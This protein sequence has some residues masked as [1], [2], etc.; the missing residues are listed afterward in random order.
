[1]RWLRL[2]V[3]Y[4][5]AVP[6]LA[7]QIT[8]SDVKSPAGMVVSDGKLYVADHATGRIWF[9]TGE[10]SDFQVFV[11]DDR[12]KT[13][14][15]LAADEQ[16]IYVSDPASRSVFRIDK[17]RRTVTQLWKGSENVTPTDVAYL[18]SYAIVDQQ[19]KRSNELVILDE[20]AKVTYRL[21]LDRTPSDLLV[22]RSTGLEWPTS[23]SRTGARLVVADRGTGTVFESIGGREWSSVGKTRFQDEAH[24]PGAFFPQVKEPRSASYWN[25]I[26]YLI[27]ENAIY[28]LVNRGTRLVPLVNRNTPIK[29]P[30]RLLVNEEQLQLLISDADAGKVVSWPLLVPITIELEARRDSSDVLGEIYRYLWKLG[31]LPTTK[32]AL[33]YAYGTNQSCVTV[34][35]L[36]TKARVLLPKTNAAI[37]E[38]LCDANPG[39][40]E[41]GIL[42][43]LPL[44][45]EFLFPLVPFENSLFV[46]EQTLDGD[47]SL[48]AI[49][50]ESI[51]DL[52][53]RSQVTDELLHSLNPGLQSTN[54]LSFK[55]KGAKV[56]IPIQ[57]N[58]YFLA[59]PRVELFSEDSGLLKIA[60]RDPRLS[61]RSTETAE[62]KASVEGE[63]RFATSLSKEYQTVL[64]NMDFHGAHRERYGNGGN[65][66]VLV[67]EDGVDCGHPVFFG[68]GAGSAF[69]SSDCLRPRGSMDGVV[70][71]W[72]ETSERHGTCV[73]SLVGARS[74]PYGEPLAPNIQVRAAKTN[75]NETDLWEA[76]RTFRRSFVLNVSAGSSA[77]NDEQN[78][79]NI[80]GKDSWSRYML[81]VAASGNENDLLKNRREFPARLAREFS[82]VISVGALD[83][84]GKYLWV[85]ADSRQG[86]NFG[87]MVEILAPGESIPCA[88]EVLEDT[89]IY[90]L[91]DGTSMATPLV[92]AVAALL[93]EKGL[94]PGEAKAR[95]LATAE[96][97]EREKNG[98]SVAMFGKLSAERALRDPENLYV[99]ILNPQ[100][101]KTE[102]V[103]GTL[104]VDQGE[105]V[106][107]A[108]GAIRTT[109][110]PSEDI[111]SIRRLDRDASGS[112]LYRLVYFV[113]NRRDR[114][115]VVLEKKVIL[116]GC[117]P[118][119]SRRDGQTYLLMFG[120]G[121]SCST[122][123]V[124]LDH[125]VTAVTDLI[126]PQLGPDRFEPDN[127]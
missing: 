29:S 44:N 88:T 1:M 71:Q 7:Q 91:V 4:V 54:I 56:S 28:A 53:L 108:P 114:G 33:P 83:Q 115:S 51:P 85:D 110:V 80:L 104:E 47:S 21:S 123:R 61:V 117:L 69:N 74:S 75:L 57:R 27:Q 32:L 77:V 82:N 68:T 25:G 102:E 39:Y 63:D 112:Y 99:A 98:D 52:S 3:F 38:I 49:I 6:I 37:E 76:F 62:P 90:S 24:S 19:I 17:E 107:R 40:C 94:T 11:S 13:P 2:S 30:A 126:G 113:R 65:V 8:P 67:A 119:V 78:W 35:C 95:I 72:A 36:V 66:A 87:D 89:A 105:I 70:T 46:S 5:V 86:S 59:V 97:V 116:T 55:Q 22:W 9:R 120:D 109:R 103:W 18:A 20:D 64:N 58:R 121:G 45:E 79:R 125:W 41:K 14:T 93:L 26:Y 84:E 43:R 111:L 16:S 81:L 118:Y 50:S 124:A 23:I 92:A 10:S 31:V 122:P 106:F 42:S 96:P 48:R 60:K 127:R 15:G 34:D 12:I 100:T 101:N 73:S